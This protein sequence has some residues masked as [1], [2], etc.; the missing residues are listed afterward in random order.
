MPMEKN[1]KFT[2]FSK[3]TTAFFRGLEK[4]NNKEWFDCNRT[5]YDE[6]VMRPAI[7][8]VK[9]MGAKLKS[10]SPHI[11]ADP[12]RDKSIFRLNRDTRF[13]NNKIP[14]K[15]HL[16]IYFWEGE[17]KKLEN[18][19]FYFQLGPNDIMLGAGMHIFP[20]HMLNPYREAV[21]DTVSGKELKKIIS[22]ISKN[23]SYKLGWAKYK[24]VPRGYDPEHPNKDFLLFGGIGYTIEENHR[25]LF[26]T[27]KL[28]DYCFKFFNDISPLH[29]W[30]TELTV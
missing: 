7:E 27:E 17:G 15:T 25:D 29:R 20:K 16:G 21:T 8:F 5:T 6:H 2:G 12:R 28:I 22:R 4:N 23:K 11:V 3:K 10:I 1:F 14:Y 19:G 24:K 26:F 9:V 18:P 13:S 30:L